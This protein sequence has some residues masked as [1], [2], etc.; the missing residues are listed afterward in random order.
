MTGAEIPVKPI[1]YGTSPALDVPDSIDGK[2]IEIELDPPVELVR[3]GRCGKVVEAD[4]AEACWWCQADLCFNCWETIGHCGHDEAEV[5]NDAARLV[6]RLRPVL[7]CE[8]YGKCGGVCN[9]RWGCAM[10]LNDDEI[11]SYPPA[12]I[13][14]MYRKEDTPPGD[15]DRIK[16]VYR[17]A[18]SAK[19]GYYNGNNHFDRLLKMARKDSC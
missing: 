19:H 17:I 5:W 7:L 12:R 3:C 6:D 4:K 9:D 15:A 2:W 11:R 16:R 10:W 18:L 14:W 1:E 13:T 8:L